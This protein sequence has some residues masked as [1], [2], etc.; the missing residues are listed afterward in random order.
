MIRYG[1]QCDKLSFI[2]QNKASVKKF[3]GQTTIRYQDL[4]VDYPFP[5]KFFGNEISVT[6]SRGL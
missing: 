6:K 5:P 1:Y 3:D 4:E 2:K